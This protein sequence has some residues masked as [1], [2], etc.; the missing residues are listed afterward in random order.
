MKDLFEQLSYDFVIGIEDDI[1]NSPEQRLAYQPF[2]E[3]AKKLG[4]KKEHI[5]S[6]VLALIYIKIKEKPWYQ[7]WKN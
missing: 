4:I 7:F 3:T 2:V 5:P 1:V 6:V